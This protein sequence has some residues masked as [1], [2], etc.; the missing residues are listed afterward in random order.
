MAAGD[1]T[2][3]NNAKKLFLDGDID[4]AVDTIKVALVT[5]Y[6][7]DIDAHDMWNDVSANEESGT[8]YSTGGETLANSEVTVIG[9]S[10][11]A[12]WDGDNVT[13]TGL[14]VGTPS[15]AIIYKST[16]DAATSP[17]IAYMELGTAS[18]GGDYTIAWNASG[19]ARLS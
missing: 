9:A 16:G 14:D 5:G 18:N 7:P 11:L 19:I 15:H 17:L 2:F 4:L 3:Y 1:I 8:G 13:W 12:M 6:T 10:D